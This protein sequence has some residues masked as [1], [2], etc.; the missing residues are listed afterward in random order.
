[1][2][3]DKLTLKTQDAVGRA[4]QLASEYANPQIEPVHILQALL[5]DNEGLV[6]TILK[7]GLCYC[8]SQCL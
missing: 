5:Q 3:L 7:K 8:K 4:Q 6:P 2:T 1:M